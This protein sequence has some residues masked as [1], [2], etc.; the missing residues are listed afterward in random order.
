MKTENIIGKFLMAIL[1]ILTSIFGFNGEVFA[2]T[3]SEPG[4]VTAVKT[5]ERLG[6]E[7][8]R[9]ATVKISVKGNPYTLSVQKDREIV[10][11]LDAS[12]SM[13][14]KI[15]G[16]K[17]KKIT[18]LKESANKFIENV[19][20]EANKGKIKIGVVWYAKNATAS[21]KLTDSVTDLKTCI[22]KGI[23]N[24][25]TN[26][27]E[28]IKVAKGL[29]TTSDNEKS[30]LVLSDGQP[31]F[32]TD[33]KGTVHGAGNAD[34][35]EDIHL[36]SD[37]IVTN[38]YY[39]E[40]I[41]GNVY[42]GY[43]TFIGKDEQPH[44]CDYTG[45]YV[46][47]YLFPEEHY[48]TKT[49]D[50]EFNR[51]PSQAAK[52]EVS[53]FTGKVYTIGFGVSSN[54]NAEN[55]LKSIVKNGGSYYSASDSSKLDEAFKLIEKNIDVVAKNLTI[56]DVV[57]KTFEVDVDA[58]KATYGDAVTISYDKDGQTIIT[59]NFK[60]LSSKYPEELTFKVIAKKDYYGSMYTNNTATVT[61]TAND[62][63]KF[64][65]K[66]DG[67]INENL[68][69]PVVPIAS[70][71][72][73]DSYE[74]NT[75]TKLNTN[76]SI[77]NNDYNNIQKDNAKSVTDEIIIVKNVEN[78]K[79]TLN[80][81][82]NFEYIP[83]KNFK[84]NDSFTYYIKTTIVRNDGTVEIAKSNV[85]TVNILVK[86]VKTSYT[87]NYYLNGTTTKVVP[88]K[89]VSDKF[90][91]DVITENAL[92]LANYNLVGNNSYTIELDEENN[93]INFYYELKTS[94]I[95]VRY[96]EKGTNK[97]LADN[98]T[99]DGKVTE[100][101]TVSAK[102]ITKYVVVGETS[103]SGVYTEETQEFTFYYEKAESAG[104]IAHH[105]IID[106]KGNKTTNKLFEDE[107]INGKLDE[108]F[109]FNAKTNLGNYE[110]VECV[111]TATGTLTDEVQEVIFYYQLKSSKINVRYLEKGTNKKLADNDTFD[112]KVTEGFN[113]IAKSIKNYVVVGETSY[114]GVYTEET[115]EFTFYYEKAESAGAIAHHYIIDNKGNKTTNKLFE[116][117]IINGKLDEQFSFNAKT[118]LGNY[119]YVECV[120]T[121]TGTLTN[122]VQEV[123]FYYQ[124]KTSKINVRYLEK[125]TN[126]KLADND[127]FDGKVTEPFTVSAKNI[128]KYVVVGETSYSGVYTEETQEFTFY[129]EKA[130]SAGA[131]AHHYII[132]NKGNK[133]TNKLFEDEII[134]GK[135]DEQFSFNAKTN[136]GNYEYVE[137]VGTATGTL[138]NEVQEVIFY[139]QLKET[140]V[141][142]RYVTEINGDY[143]DL[144]KS[145]S[146][147]DRIG[148]AF[149]A[150]A[151]NIPNYNLISEKV[152][153]I[154]LLPEKNIIIFVYELKDSKVIVRHY[155]EGTTNKIADDVELIGKIDSDYTTDSVNKEGYILTVV[156][157]NK[158][159]KFTDE[160]IEV[161]YYYKK[162]M[163]NVIIRYVDED[164]KELLE[165][166]TIT[167][168][169]GTD[170]ETTSETI[171]DYELIKTIGNE[172]GKYAE[173]DITVTY[174]YQYVM[175]E[176]GD[177]TPD[178]P[179]TGIESNNIVIYSTIG[180]F[181][182]GALAL[183]LKKFANK[184]N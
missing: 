8:S 52:D 13:D 66:V 125:G 49:C 57:P 83:N 129:Y 119:E 84:G 50:A 51:T 60:E 16:S 168:Q 136:L 27:Q 25:G 163:S 152:Q 124:L 78:G 98:D 158:S 18:T 75:N 106:N 44:R 89:T 91:G 180:T 127:T 17:D 33:S 48:A 110:Y 15:K 7:T 170:Y 82:G 88:S 120:G 58:L 29:F 56:T 137:C 38:K 162:Q 54:S 74:T 101:F 144:I 177:D 105:Y 109:S 99:F 156:P 150:T 146:Y 145:E 122:E 178:I 65:E 77:R 96:L 10:L 128:T 30:L 97:K 103:Y 132:D 93:V 20:T 135:L 159:G 9:S 3:V 169:V 63:N 81:D 5:A 21:C 155:E 1:M 126:K 79:L 147:T 39:S 70:R 131:I 94:K 4:K 41:R 115:Q 149:E 164:N 80:Q 72:E 102:N 161:I 40:E 111:G 108:Q 19:L 142:I 153:V 121:A 26:V 76:T 2:D 43:K 133:T 130:E 113:V 123:I 22:D 45:Y 42:D 167:G 64:Y 46:N 85:S 160:V 134:N 172:T 32:Y 114:S 90:V 143:V 14:D 59:Y 166:K 104:A 116:D 138:T 154:E 73:K 175:G 71:T 69:D 86:G 47:G 53:S 62:G 151:K 31:T 183:I 107:I 68:I 173:E 179:Y 95:N 157:T 117:E 174:V 184:E 171:E 35:H 176:G 36:N 67:K 34:S 100:P 140:S 92:T 55:F 148:N 37:F 139:Y 23:A 87:V 11:V 112:G 181:L 141:I 24:G 118:N 61:G 12:G 28:G 182:L 6:D 165:S